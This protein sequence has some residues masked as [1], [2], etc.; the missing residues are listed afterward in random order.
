MVDPNAPLIE[1]VTRKNFTDEGFVD[2]S[3]GATSILNEGPLKSFKMLFNVYTFDYY[4]LQRVSQAIQSGRLW[5]YYDGRRK[6]I[7]GAAGQAQYLPALDAMFTNFNNVGN[8]WYNG[9]VVHEALHA[10]CD[11]RLEF[12]SVDKNTLE[13]LAFAGQCLYYRLKGYKGQGRNAFSAIPDI[14]DKG[15]DVF[16]AAFALADYWVA[17]PNGSSSDLESKLAKTVHAL[18]GYEKFGATLAADYDGLKRK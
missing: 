6:L 2:F 10:V 14:T 12:A 13:C 5:V 11:E 17:N 7:T 15:L 4:D 9:I 1:Q 18:P 8:F 3:S 16:V